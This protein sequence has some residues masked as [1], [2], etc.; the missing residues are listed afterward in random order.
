ME[1]SDFVPLVVIGSPGK[2]RS[3]SL[4]LLVT[5]LETV[6][7]VDPVQITRQNRLGTVVNE[8]LS[9]VMCGK[10]L[11]DS[12]LGCAIAHKNARIQ[13]DIAIASSDIFKWVLIVEDDVDLGID[14]FNIINR[15]L[16]T[17]DFKS[18][19]IVN[20][21]YRNTRGSLTFRNINERGTFRAKRYLAAGA[22]CYAI[23]REGLQVLHRF[24]DVPI[25]YVADWPMPFAHLK[26][27][28]PNQTQV[29]DIQGATSMGQRHQP[30]HWLIMLF[31]QLFYLRKIARLYEISIWRTAGYLFLATPARANSQRIQIVQSKFDTC[32]TA[33]EGLFRRF[34]DF[35]RFIMHGKNDTSVDEKNG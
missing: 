4:E 16:T 26:V 31:S 1:K 34:S 27:Y 9:E 30:K 14:S 23:N 29:F 22:V 10:R 17:V 11:S 2:L 5:K 3:T 20:Y 19:A 12:E 18:P 13:A 28:I 24:G 25:D 15:E 32:R 8:Q 35:Q 21:D 7:F 6:I 33:A